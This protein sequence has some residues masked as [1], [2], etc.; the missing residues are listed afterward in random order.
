MQQISTKQHPIKVFDFFTGCGGTCRGFS[1]AGMDIVCA[2]DNDPIAGKTFKRNFPKTHF[3]SDDIRNVACDSLQ[4][5]IKACEGHPILFSGCA[6]C[7]PFTKQKTNKPVQD[8]RRDLLKEFLRFI[9]YYRVDFIFVENVP[10]LQNVDKEGPFGDFIMALS[11][12]GYSYEFNII[13]SQSYGVPQMRK[14]LILIA[15]RLGLV[16]FPTE[17]NGPHTNREY[18]KVREWISDL[19]QIA[20]GERHPT[21]PNHQAAALSALNLKRISFLSEG[22][23]REQWPKRLRLKCHS[24]GYRGHTDVYGRM[25]WDSVATGLTTRCVSLSNGRFGHPSQNRAISAREAA[26]LQTFPR[27]FIF[28]GNLNEM[29]RQIGNAVPVI[30]AER[31]GRNFIDHLNS[32]LGEMG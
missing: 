27:D 29:S 4:P 6:P 1:N 22:E 11:K 8:T 14:R 10:G 3:I 28:E 9:E 21:I 13:A 23:G 7:Q 24:N 19:P 16:S 17:T 12:M 15:S 26:S 2:L 5:L 20:A 32:V 18:S 30:L 31:F 25:S